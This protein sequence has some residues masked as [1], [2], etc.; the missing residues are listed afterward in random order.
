MHPWHAS[1]WYQRA[2]GC[3]HSVQP[4]LAPSGIP[5]VSCPRVAAPRTSLL[6]AVSTR[7][8]PCPI[9]SPFMVLSILLWRSVFHPGYFSCSLRL[10]F[11]FSSVQ[12]LS[13]VRLF[14]TP[15]IAA[16]QASLCITNSQSSLRLKSIESVMPSSHLILW[17]PL[18]LLPPIP[19]ASESFPLVFLIMKFQWNTFSQLAFIRK[20]VC[21]TF[22]LEAILM[23]TELQVGSVFLALEDVIPLSP[24]LY[25][26]CWKLHY[27]SLSPFWRRCDSLPSG[28]STGLLSPS[29]AAA[30]PHGLGTVSFGSIL[31][32]ICAISCISG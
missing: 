6:T 23:G 7:S 11:Q 14:A 16:R 13:R 22:T 30:P 19:P 10:P 1:V 27:A 32:E 2:W 28:C 31:P 3:L 21:F 24:S 5:G 20:H 29:P 25:S 8:L 9:Y 26:F 4:L 12:S 17:R 18:L 15:W